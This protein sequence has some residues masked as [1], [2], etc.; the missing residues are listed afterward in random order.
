MLLSDRGDDA[1]FLFFCSMSAGGIL[2]KHILESIIPS[3]LSTLMESE[4]QKGK[5][6]TSSQIVSLYQ[7]KKNKFQ[8]YSCAH[9]ELLI[10]LSSSHRECILGCCA[11][12][13]RDKEMKFTG[14]GC[15]FQTVQSQ[16]IILLQ[17]QA[18]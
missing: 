18:Q 17:Q 14:G 7:H 5:G 15:I 2:T 12:T 6:H 16:D 3:S 10:L 9:G 4:C 1:M 13:P 11:P 8:A